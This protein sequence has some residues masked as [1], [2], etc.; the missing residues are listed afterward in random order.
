VVRH[1]ARNA[2]RS[3]KPPTPTVKRDELT[4]NSGRSDGGVGEWGRLCS[5]L[6]RMIAQTFLLLGK[7]LRNLSSNIP[8]PTSAEGEDTIHSRPMKK[9]P[10]LYGC[11]H[12]DMHA[13][14]KTQHTPE[15]SF[16][17][18]AVAVVVGLT[19]SF[20]ASHL[21]HGIIIFQYFIRRCS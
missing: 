18:L 11:W 1:Y 19:P 5:S 8:S 6:C 9:L 13:C 14:I 2:D 20:P 17:S 21:I 7:T 4:N 10:L 15:A 3:S 16:P 12:H